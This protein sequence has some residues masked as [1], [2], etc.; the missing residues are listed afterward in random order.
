MPPQFEA[1]AR[2]DHEP[3]FVPTRQEPLT[4][5]CTASVNRSASGALRSRSTVALHVPE[6]SPALATTFARHEPVHSL[7]DLI[8]D[9]PPRMAV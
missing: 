8:A 5:F 7:A 4:T 3:E 6:N 1:D 2:I 9:H